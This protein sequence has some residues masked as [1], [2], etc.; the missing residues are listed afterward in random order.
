MTKHIALAVTG[1]VL[2]AAASAFAQT[3]AQKSFAQLKSLAGTWEGK[4]GEGKPVQV[5]FRETAGGATM[6]SEI[7]GRGAEDMVTMFYLDGDKLML[8]HYCGAGNQPRMQ[9]TISPDGKTFAFDFV[10]ATNLPS[11]DAGHMRRAVFSIVDA[12][13]HSE[14]WTYANHGKEM[15]E[16]FDLHRK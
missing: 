6:M 2:L 9:A 4:T 10:D 8:T 7:L 3:D 11:L 12:N 16:V 1:V 13:R 15:K 14:E 5:S